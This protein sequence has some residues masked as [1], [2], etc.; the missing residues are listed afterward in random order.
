[1]VV[2]G[3]GRDSPCRNHHWHLPGRLPGDVVTGKWNNIVD[4][5]NVPLAV[6]LDKFLATVFRLRK[7]YVRRC[8][9]AIDKRRTFAAT[10][11]IGAVVPKWCLFTAAAVGVLLLLLPSV[12]LSVSPAP[13]FFAMSSANCACTL[14]DDVRKTD[15]R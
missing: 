6:D 8:G 5:H 14:S 11:A 3:C 2:G 13:R 1:M 10:V 7:R 15:A 12:S 4:Y 9:N